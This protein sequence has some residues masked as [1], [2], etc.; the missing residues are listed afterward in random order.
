[1]P[2]SDGAQPS[3]RIGISVVICTKNRAESLQLTLSHLANA[4]RT[5]I[6]AEIVVVDNGSTDDTRAV[7]ESF[8]A[9]IP[10]RYYLEPRQGTFGKSHALNR[11][12][13]EGGLLEIVAVLDDDMTVR[14]DWFQGVAAICERWPDS[15]LFTG[16][17][18]VIWPTDDVPEWAREAHLQGAVFSSVITVKDAPLE[19]GQWYLGGHFW[20][21]ERVVHDGTLRFKD[22]W[23]TEPEFQL[24]MIERGSRGT[25]GPD[26]VAGHRV[27]MSLLRREFALQRAHKNNEVAMVRLRPYRSTV[28][29]AR[30]FRSHPLVTRLF[31]VARIVGWAAFY[32]FSLVRF[33]PERRFIG[34]LRG[35]MGMS[36]SMG[37]LRVA[38]ECPEYSV[39]PSVAS[40][41]AQVR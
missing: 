14:H 40:K 22:I 16:T 32:C 6:A 5:G 29:Q 28:K 17:T 1:M 37:Y 11:A 35:L 12:L 10:V 33:S 31:C 20:F 13:N 38:R 27:Q 36:I 24:N 7:A 39:W 34:R 9:R 26:A 2:A 30:F 19:S 18:Y 25:A 41:A 21:R 23:L 15:D 8:A 3:S 4:D